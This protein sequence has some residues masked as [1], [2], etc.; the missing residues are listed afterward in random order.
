[1]SDSVRRWAVLGVLCLS[2]MVIGIDNT[3]LNVALPTLVRSIHASTSELQWIVDAYILVFAGLLLTAGS[4]G[5]RF[6]R[7]GALSIGLV[8]FGASSAAA[9]FSANSG[10]LIAFR[11]LMGVGGALIMPATLSILINVFTNAKERGR[12]IGVWAGVAGIGIAIGP[13]G[14]GF[15]LEHFWWGSVFLVN[16]PISITALILGRVLVPTSKDPSAPRLDPIGALLS[17]VALSLLLWT[18]IGAPTR[19]WGNSTT[20]GGFALGFAALAA[21]VA[22]E[23]HNDHPMLDVS[24]F[25]NPRF[26]VASLAITS[27]FFA[28]SGGLF[29]LTQL[30]QSVLGFDALSAGLRIAPLA[31][32]M[33]IVGP[34]SPRL[35]ERFGTKRMVT[36]GLLVT[37]GALLTFASMRAD[38][39]YL[40]AFIGICAMAG[41]M[42]LV[43]APATESIMGSLPKEKAGVGSAINDTTR[44]TGGA[45]GVAVIGSILVSGYH[46]GLSGHLGGL[47]A[48]QRTAAEG[49]VSGAVQVAHGLGAPVGHA[50]VSA[51]RDA[52]IQGM[53]LS[54]IIGAVV[55]VLGAVLAYALLPA[56][57]PH[58]ELDAT[59]YLPVD[60][61]VDPDELAPAID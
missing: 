45:L 21:F 31:V 46:S 8:I 57:A 32:V 23:L 27:G 43:M 11:A 60:I 7:R 25:R 55:V 12:A 59:E 50:L 6:G 29:L 14:G 56:R 15:L 30:L 20:L 47:T 4:L 1:M 52:F 22:W 9:A 24:F 35:V 17:M 36:L 42:S 28:V 54:F 53:R 19:G 18:I 33:M 2:L 34:V 58:H 44:Q 49:S 5:D 13:I 10:Q 38:S 37:A 16:V 40:V 48:A 3:I 39:P 41:G 26:T 51:A 61:V